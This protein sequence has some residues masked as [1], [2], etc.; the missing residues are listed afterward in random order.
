PEGR[1][2]A[3]Q[4]SLSQ[5][6]DAVVVQPLAVFFGEDA[7]R[8]GGGGAAGSH[9]ERYSTLRESDDGQHG[10]LLE[11]PGYLVGRP[12]ENPAAIVVIRRHFGRWLARVAYSRERKLRVPPRKFPVVQP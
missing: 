12:G 4:V 11:L 3:A 7:T 8:F 5:Q 10:N 9:M 2:G 1:F 6:A